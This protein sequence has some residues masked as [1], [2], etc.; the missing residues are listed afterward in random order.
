MGKKPEQTWP[1]PPVPTPWLAISG[2]SSSDAILLIQT[3]KPRSALIF[4][5]FFPTE[6]RAE[7]EATSLVKRAHGGSGPWRAE[8]LGGV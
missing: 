3:S 5:F 1:M 2:G 4:L 6:V 8:E 7:G